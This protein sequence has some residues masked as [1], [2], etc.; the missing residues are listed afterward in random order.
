[1]LIL[2]PKLTLKKFKTVSLP[3]TKLP[4]QLLRKLLLLSKKSLKIKL[5]KSQLTRKSGPMPIPL[6][7]LPTLKS[8]SSLDGFLKVKATLL[9]TQLLLT[10][11]IN[12]HGPRHKKRKIPQLTPLQLQHGL[13]P[14]KKV[15]LATPPLTKRNLHA[16]HSKKMLPLLK[17]T[18]LPSKPLLLPSKRRSR[19]RRL[20]LLKN[21]QP[22]RLPAKPRLTLKL[23]PLAHSPRPNPPPR[24]N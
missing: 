14:K 12:S 16:K 2:L 6:M 1:M 23:T 17:R 7:K 9:P 8:P 3:H 22:R 4:F 11:L 21:L 13:M 24:K 18:C 19:L 20:L 15:N 5:A 10:I